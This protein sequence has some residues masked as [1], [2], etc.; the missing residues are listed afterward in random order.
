MQNANPT[1]CPVMKNETGQ[2]RAKPGGTKPETLP[3][4][5]TVLGILCKSIPNRANRAV[6]EAG[7]ISLFQN[8]ATNRA[9]RTA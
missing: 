9:T 2:N 1:G 4:L 7:E 5:G 8:R 3:G 6:S